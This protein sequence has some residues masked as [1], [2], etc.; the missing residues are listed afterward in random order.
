VALAVHKRNAFRLLGSEMRS[1][2]ARP[3]RSLYVASKLPVARISRFKNLVLGR[4]FDLSVAY[5]SR[6]V[7]QRINTEQRSKDAPTDILSFSLSKTSGEILICLPEVVTH[8]KAWEMKPQSYLDYL[9]IHGLLHIK[10]HDH[11]RIMERL[12]QKY[13]KALHVSCPTSPALHGTTHRSRH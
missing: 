7:M 6:K 2:K 3:S 12:E 13:T 5:V 11:G 4:D 8:A 1:S 10:G 9:F